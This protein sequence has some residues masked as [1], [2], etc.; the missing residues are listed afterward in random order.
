MRRNPDFVLRYISG[1]PY[2]LVTGKAAARMRKEI[3]LNSTGAD[4]WNLL[5]SDITLDELVEKSCLFFECEGEEEKKLVSDKVKEFSVQMMIANAFLEYSAN[6]FEKELRGFEIRENSY[7]D[8]LERPLVG[9]YKIGEI[10]IEIHGDKRIIPDNFEL[11]SDDLSDVKNVQKIVVKCCDGM[12]ESGGVGKRFSMHHS[13]FLFDER[14]CLHK[15]RAGYVAFLNNHKFVRWLFISKDGKYAE[16]GMSSGDEDIIKNEIYEATR[17]V[18][19]YF[20][21]KCGYTVL[22]SASI[23]HKDKAILFS[24]MSGV[25]KSTHASLWVK[26][27]KNVIFNGDVNLIY[28]ENGKTYICGLPWCGTSEMYNKGKYE[29]GS[30][31]M[32]K[33]SEKNEINELTEQEKTT[34]IMHRFISPNW[35]V[36]DLDILLKIA[37]N[38]VKCTDVFQLQCNMDDEAAIIC[39]ERVEN[40]YI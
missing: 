18:F 28:I 19:L 14:M 23:I 1:A 16:I 20:A 22:H 39:K 33:Q 40:N 4:I 10:G 17:F 12:N 37:E 6:E 13:Y 38:V 32:L 35:S 26:L 27:F 7:Y 9:K 5:D 31:V 21:Q 30:I 3:N 11:F 8:Q 29:V 24:A 15:A 25:G 34:H 2:L 36:E